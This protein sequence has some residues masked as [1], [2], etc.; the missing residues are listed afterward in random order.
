M[1]AESDTRWS[2]RRL[3]GE[4]A[5]YPACGLSLA[6]R[7][8]WRTCLIERV[9]NNP[10]S[11]PVSDSQVAPAADRHWLSLLLIEDDRGDAVLVEEMIADSGADI[12]VEWAPSLAHA[13]GALARE[14]PACVLLHL[15]L[16]DATG[17]DGIARV[18]AGE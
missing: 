9:L 16:P 8:A 18:T 1:L 2:S 17:F 13:D 15:L 10:G 3:D 11:I 7:D 4:P 5:K 14:R 6:R 12:R